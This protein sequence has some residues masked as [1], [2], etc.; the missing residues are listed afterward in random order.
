LSEIAV[1]FA[2]AVF[3]EIKGVFLPEGFEGPKVEAPRKAGEPIKEPSAKT[4]E[5]T[6][7]L[8]KETA[9][10][11]EQNAIPREKLEAELTELRQ[12]ATKP[13]SVRRPTDQRFDAELDAEGHTFDRT[14][15]DKSWC[16]R[17][18]EVCGLN[19]GGDL[20][21]KVDASLSQKPAETPLK[22]GPEKPIEAPKEAEP[23]DPKRAELQNELA[24][25]Q[26][27]KADA[28][29]RWNDL[30]KQADESA[31][32][33]RELDR[34]AA[35][36]KGEAKAKLSEQHRQATEEAARAAKE[37]QTAF[38][39]AVDAQKGIQ[40]KAAQ[41]NTDPQ[42]VLPCFAAGT[43]VWTP[44]GTRK[45]EDIKPFDLVMAYDLKRDVILP[46]RVLE[47]HRNRTVG[48][49]NIVVQGA[50]IRATGLHRFWVESDADWIAARHLQPGMLVRTV[51]GDLSEITAVTPKVSPYS[52]SFNLRIEE[53]CTYFVGPGVLV[54]NTGGPA[55][56]FGNLRIYEGV[57]LQLD[58]N[59]KPKFADQIYI[60][61]TDDLVRRQ[62]EHRAEAVEKLK[63][64]SLT[65]EQREFWEFKKKIEL[66]E[67]VS[68]LNPDQANYLEQKNIDIERH[69]RGDKNIMNR[70]EQ[71]ARENMPGLE[72]KIKADPKVQEAGL[73]K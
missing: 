63:D 50:E 48:F 53:A 29:K 66:R 71:V 45:I 31:A 72:E 1:D 16:R 7:D 73:C 44:D 23:I 60:G 40:R 30:R 47:L 17:S 18:D 3:A 41:L 59:G 36:A 8:P 22:G 68:G 57:N 49:Y 58:A 64:P 51:A 61:Q 19:L 70:R 34:Q 20:N 9:A 52:E 11:A 46:R 26:K 32:R 15:G 6:S 43:P 67:R 24:D 27:R 37:S 54:H 14:K 56:G 65:P 13:E 35:I 33:A 28:E 2:K 10:K 21:A 38:S 42:S 5:P 55:Y 69:A 4:G 25:L 12:K 39:E 62:E